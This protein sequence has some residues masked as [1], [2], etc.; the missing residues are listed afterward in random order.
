MTDSA[1]LIILTVAALAL[2]HSRA[3]VVSDAVLPA[4][5]SAEREVDVTRWRH[6]G[7][8][9]L[10]WTNGNGEVYIDETASRVKTLIN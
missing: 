6:D 3:K 1:G 8:Q 7:T 5:P 9:P 2:M 10:F 4:G